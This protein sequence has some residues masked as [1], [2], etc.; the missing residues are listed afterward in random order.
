[1]AIARVRPMQNEATRGRLFF[2]FLARDMSRE[3]VDLERMSMGNLR[4]KRKKRLDTSKQI[5]VKFTRHFS[6]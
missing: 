1:M 4:K 3:R 5:A 6:V 2:F